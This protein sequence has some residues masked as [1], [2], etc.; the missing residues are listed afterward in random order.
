MKIALLICDHVR[1]E[2]QTEHQDYCDMFVKLFKAVDPSIETETF[3]VVDSVFPGTLRGFDAWLVSGSRHGVS[4]N[5]PW[6]LQLSDLI[7]NLAGLRQKIIGIC[8]GHQ[9]IAQALGGKVETSAKGWGVGMSSNQIYKKP[10]W[11][12]AAAD[13]FNLIVSHKDQVTVRPKEAVLI[14]G[15]DFCENYLLQYGDRI[16][17]LQGHPEFSRSYIRALMKTRRAQYPPAVYDKANQ[18]LTLV[19]HDKQVAQ[20]II[21]FISQG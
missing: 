20:W 21:N 18:S 14:A 17:S 1:P 10:F 4:D 7:L 16:L 9:L 3:A 6:I 19:C 13:S 12:T 5:L 11:L 2:L 8:F 15:S